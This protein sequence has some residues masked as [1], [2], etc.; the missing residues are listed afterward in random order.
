MLTNNIKTEQDFKQL[1]RELEIEEEFN[2]ILKQAIAD[3]H[4]EELPGG[5]IRMTEKGLEYQKQMMANMGG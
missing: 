2:K 5:H 3:G 1:E 4:V